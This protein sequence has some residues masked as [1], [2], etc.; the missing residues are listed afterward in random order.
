MAYRMCRALI[1]PLSVAVVD[2]CGERSIGPVGGSTRRAAGVVSR[3]I[4]FPVRPSSGITGDPLPGRSGR[5]RG[6]SS[7]GRRA[8][9]RRRPMSTNRYRAISATPTAMTFPGIGRIDF[10]RRS[11]LPIDPMCRVARWRA[12]PFPGAT[13]IG[14][15]TSCGVTDSQT[16]R[17]LRVPS[18]VV[19]ANAWT[20]TSRPSSMVQLSAQQPVIPA[21]AQ[22]AA[23]SRS[24]AGVSGIL[25]PRLRGNDS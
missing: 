20:H 24:I 14:P 23:A 4:R 9:K 12:S 8:A 6:A 3:P 15:S 16:L 17:G 19:L 5:Q 22:Y 10:R 13:V 2:A 11:C 7:M 1:G 18:F 25:D 21:K